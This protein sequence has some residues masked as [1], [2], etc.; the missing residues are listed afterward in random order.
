[1]DTTYPSKKD[2]W[3]VLLLGSSAVTM[4]AAAV[5]V[6]MQPG[7]WTTRWLV[8]GLMALVAIFTVDL[9]LRTNYTLSDELLRIRCGVFRWRVPYDSIRFVKR[10][11]TLLS[12]PALSLDRLVAS[13]SDGLLPVIISPDDQQ[14]FLKDLAE[15]APGLQRI[16]EGLIRSE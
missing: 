12:G 15:R 3:L 6:W 8:S 5:A 10:S 1:M 7:G 13:C 4:I 14:R 16:P 11:R 2:A 9:L